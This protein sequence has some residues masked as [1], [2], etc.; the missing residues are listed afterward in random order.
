VLQYAC[1]QT[2]LQQKITAAADTAGAATKVVQEACTTNAN[3]VSALESS[4]MVC[5]C[6]WMFVFVRACVCVHTGV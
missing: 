2:Q 1:A 6:M 3:G 5:V 4:N